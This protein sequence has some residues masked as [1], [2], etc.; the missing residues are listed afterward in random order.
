MSEDRN[1]E[2]RLRAEIEERARRVDARAAFGD[3]QRRLR[4]RRSSRSVQRTAIAG[5]LLLGSAFTF[6]W[7]TDVIGPGSPALG[8]VGSTLATLAVR[9]LT[10]VMRVET[11][12]GGAT[13]SRVV[14]DVYRRRDGTRTPPVL[15]RD[16]RA[17]ATDPADLFRGSAVCELTMVRG[18]EV[19][20]R[21]SLVD[22]SGGC[23]P[24]QTVMVPT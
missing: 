12:G 5:L 17:G 20:L 15:T 21:I 6:G 10:V 3:V 7:L 2:E 24:P 16:L 18:P 13:S 8:P 9:D 23:F 19:R 14:L 22:R 1:L 11:R 4:R